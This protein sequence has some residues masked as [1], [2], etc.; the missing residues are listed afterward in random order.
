M[1]ELIEHLFLLSLSLFLVL[2]PLYF[3]FALQVGPALLHFVRELAT[4]GISGRISFKPASPNGVLLFK[5]CGNILIAMCS[6]LIYSNQVGGDAGWFSDSMI[7]AEDSKQIVQC[8][9]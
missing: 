7:A 8:F 9:L 2:S 3:L 1:P 5:F 4:N 6:K